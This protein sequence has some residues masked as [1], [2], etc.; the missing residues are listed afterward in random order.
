[1]QRLEVD[2]FGGNEL[3]ACLCAEVLDIVYEERIGQRLSDEENNLCPARCEAS[4]DFC[5]NTC[6][7]SL[8]R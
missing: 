5:T 4:D 1:M 6:R 7:A 8:V 3:V 2:M